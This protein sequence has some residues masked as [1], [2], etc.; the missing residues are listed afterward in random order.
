[1]RCLPHFFPDNSGFVFTQ[2][3]SSS[4]WD[5]ATIMA[6]RFDDPTPKQVLVGGSD[7]RLLSTGHLIYRRK[8]TLMAVA[9]DPTRFEVIGQPVPVLEGVGAVRVTHPSQLDVADDGT[10]VYAAR[11]TQLRNNRALA[12][13]DEDGITTVASKTRGSFEWHAISPDGSLVAIGGIVGLTDNA[14][15]ISSA[16]LS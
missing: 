8:N 10:L 15:S 4:D 5:K 6:L 12:W 1:M 14:K 7:A 9:F 13:L 11:G 3:T 2:T 16:T